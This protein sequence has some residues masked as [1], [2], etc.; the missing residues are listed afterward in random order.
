MDRLS[1]YIENLVGGIIMLAL[2]VITLPVRVID[3]FIYKN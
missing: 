1:C 2:L 3:Y